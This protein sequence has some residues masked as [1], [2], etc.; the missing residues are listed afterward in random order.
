[1]HISKRLIA[2]SD[3]VDS[4][5]KTIYDVGCDHALLDIYLADKY[6]N[7]SFYAIDV[8]EKCIEKANQNII[9]QGLESRIKT[10]VNDGLKNIKLKKNSTLII[11]GMGAHTIIK[12]LENCDITK[13]KKIIIQSNNDLEYVRKRITNMNFFIENEI[14]VFDKKYYVIISF[15]PGLKKYNSIEFFYGPRLLNNIEENRD[16]FQYLYDK[17]NSILKNIPFIKIS[18]KIIIFLKVQKIKK[19]LQK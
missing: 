1:M 7:T 13:F 15:V 17:Y 10:N 9:K 4:K 14:S 5:D 11:S 3:F 16:Y 8:S 19:L 6:R 2:I 12:I 18:K